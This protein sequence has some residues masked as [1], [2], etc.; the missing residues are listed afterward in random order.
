[1]AIDRVSMT[2]LMR[3]V[4][5]GKF[6]LG[7]VTMTRRSDRVKQLKSISQCVKDFSGSDAQWVTF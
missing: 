4:L 1:M 2:T 7:D 5:D 3:L 6:D